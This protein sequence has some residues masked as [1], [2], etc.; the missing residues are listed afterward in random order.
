MPFTICVVGCGDIA[1]AMHGPS[2][3][4]YQAENKDAVFAGCCDIDAAK[5]EAFKDRFSFC[6]AYTDMNEMLAKE[7]PDAVCLLSP[8]Q[9]TVALA[10][11]I[12]EM[13]IPLLLEKPPGRTR[14]EVSRLMDIAARKGVPN[15]VA[16]NRRYAPLY[17]K[18]RELL[19]AGGASGQLQ[20][21]HYDMF[22]VGRLDDD[23]STTAI[24]AIDAVRFIAGA[25]FSHIRYTYREY[26]HLGT[27]V[28]DIYMT[29]AMRNGAAASINICPVTGIVREAVTVNCLD[30]TLIVDLLGNP[31][32]PAGRLIALQKNKIT[33]DLS[34]DETA[35]GVMPFER[36]GFFDEN[37]S[38]FD[39]I[40]AGG[41][42]SG[43]LS[44]TLQSV[45]A[46]DCIRKRMPE[47][48]FE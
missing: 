32:H 47:I 8:V 30:N 48:S 22:R 42:P 5:A 10:S 17:R 44:T 2:F 25:D 1:S 45:V 26:P 46:A 4:K 27:N 29:C 14:E 20:S 11:Q 19:G 16:F 35:D 40:I 3:A 34:G 18:L 9:L 7:K 24:H 41:Q 33:L 37:K 31:L 43:D 38:F 13:G 6:C 15:R 23:F 28:A 39:T 36:E 12:L 21:L